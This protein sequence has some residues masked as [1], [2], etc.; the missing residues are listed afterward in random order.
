M[1]GNYKINPALATCLKFQNNKDLYGIQSYNDTCY[2]ICAAF[3]GT[4]D[5]FEMDPKCT[6]SCDRLI[7]NMRECSF[8]VG[9][10]DHQAPNRPVAWQ[11]TPRYYPSLLKKGN[12]RNSAYR[13]CVMMCKDDAE[14]ISDCMVDFNATEPDVHNEQ[15]AMAMMNNKT[16]N[17]ADNKYFFM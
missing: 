13:Q 1:S 12:D 15:I 5:T 17:N 4:F 8:G 2:N 10:C 16:K 6:Q 11:N 9:F 14:C 7:E 3:S